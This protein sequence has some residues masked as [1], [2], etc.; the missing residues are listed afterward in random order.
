[1]NK[2]VL[3]DDLPPLGAGTYVERKN[4]QILKNVLDAYRPHG[5]AEMLAEYLV[6]RFGRNV[7]ELTLMAAQDRINRK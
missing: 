3:P 6:Q 4:A 2:T 1:M 7:A 5:M